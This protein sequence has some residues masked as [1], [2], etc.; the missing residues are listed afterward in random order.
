MMPIIKIAINNINNV[1]FVVCFKL[2]ITS[3]NDAGQIV[4]LKPVIPW[5][6]QQKGNNKKLVIVKV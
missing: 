5:N 6:F 4:N 1:F 3:A 2:I